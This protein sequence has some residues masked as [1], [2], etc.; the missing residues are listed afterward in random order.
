MIQALKIAGEILAL[1][2]ALREAVKALVTAF[3][4][5][6]DLAARRAYESARRAAFEARQR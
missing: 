4:T 3:R 2:P 5:G 1:A 6:D